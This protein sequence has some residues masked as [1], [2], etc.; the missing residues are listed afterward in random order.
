MRLPREATLLAAVCCILGLLLTGCTGSSDSRGKGT[1]TST[2]GSRQAGQESA[3]ASP[4]VGEV[5]QPGPATVATEAGVQTRDQI[6]QALPAPATDEPSGSSAWPPNASI[7]SYTV[8]QGDT[9]QSIATVLGVSARD[10][11]ASNEIIGEEE[12]RVGRVFYATTGGLVHTVKAGQTLSDI[13]ATY[14]VPSSAITLA[15]GLNSDSPMFAGT[16]L[17]IPAADSA[18]WYTVTALSRGTMAQFIWPS[19]GA[20][21]SA[22]G[23]RQHPVRQVRHHHDGIDID[24]PEGSTV[25][26]SAGGKVTSYSEEPAGYGNVLILEHGGGFYTLYGHLKSVLVTTGQYIEKG[27]PVAISGNT[28]ISAGPHLHFELRNGEFPLDPMSFLPSPPPVQPASLPR[29][30]TAGSSASSNRV[31][32]LRDMEG[33]YTASENGVTVRLQIW[34]A[35]DDTARGSLSS[36][37][38]GT[39]SCVV[40]ML[41]TT[42]HLLFLDLSELTLRRTGTAALTFVDSGVV[43]RRG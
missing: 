34:D 23:W 3:P 9:V 10:L 35:D 19:Q 20:V 1:P 32:T 8:K 27:Q 12:P 26:A 22:F 30:A 5:T 39:R 24:V 18:F 17:A 40:C 42:I 37:N 16:R 4:P 36:T 6:R 2:A 31:V 33:T 11:R 41:D 29:P 21:V 38:A 13:S 15:N 7:L 28:G 43:L 25:Y 14:D